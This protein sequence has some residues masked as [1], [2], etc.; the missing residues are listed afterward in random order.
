MQLPQVGISV[1]AMDAGALVTI[2]GRVSGESDVSALLK[3]V[4]R[5]RPRFLVLNLSKAELT[6]V[7]SLDL[8]LKIATFAAQAGIALTAVRPREDRIDVMVLTRL[9]LICETFRNESDAAV[10]S[11][12]EYA[13]RAEA[14]GLYAT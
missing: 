11:A 10:A 6:S 4:E 9:V 8:V 7:A 3:E 14:A 1:R 12:R 2:E 13:I 5:L